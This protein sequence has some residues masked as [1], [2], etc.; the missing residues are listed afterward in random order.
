MPH[1]TFL[2]HGG[3]MGAAMR[4]KDWSGVPLGPPQDWPDPLKALV[5][6]VLASRQPMFL[7]WGDLHRVLLYNDAYAVLLGDKH[8]H[9]LGRAFTE[10][11][12][13]AC[14]PLTELV[15]TVF[16]GQ[17]LFNEDILLMLDRGNGLQEAHFTYSYTPV[18]DADGAVLG[19]FCACSE[20][21]VAVSERNDADQNLS[22][23]T[24]MFE[25]APGWICMLEGPDHRFKL[26]NRAHRKIL[27][28][29]VVIGMTVAEL[30]P[31][32]VEQ[33]FVDLL[34][35]VYASGEALRA[36][37]MTF[38]VDDASGLQGE[39]RILDFVYQPLTNA[40][41]EVTGIFCEGADVTDRARVEAELRQREQELRIALNAGGFGTWTHNFGSNALTT[42][43]IYRTMFGFDPNLRLTYADLLSRVHPDDLERRQAALD[44]S[45]SQHCDYKVD[46]RIM[47]TSREVRWLSVWGQWSYDPDGAPLVLSGVSADITERKTLEEELRCLNEDLERRVL[48]RT[49]ELQ[50]AE[51]ALRQAQKMEAVGQLTGGIAHDFNNLLMG[52]SG[53]LELVQTRLAQDRLDTLPRYIEAARSAVARAAALTQRLLAFSRR[54]TLDPGAVEL[55]RLVGGMED[56]IGRTVGPDIEMSVTSAPDLWR[57]LVD[58]HQF[59]NALLNLCINA[60]DAMP[61]GGLLTIE[62]ENKTVEVRSAVSWDLPVGDYTCLSVTDTGCGMSPEVISR[63]F[64]PFFT[65]KPLGQG[66]G[67]GLS[68]IYGFVRQ[69]GGEV[70]IYSEVGRGTTVCIY[71]PR[72]HGDTE[73]SPP[74]LV[75]RGLGMEGHGE[76]VL[77]V[78]DEA[79]VRMLISEVLQDAGYLTI[80]VED[81]PAGMNVLQSNKRIDLLITDVGLP[82]GMNGRQVADAA[83][84][85]RPELKV[86]FVTGYAENAVVRNGRLEDGMQII[87]KP[88]SVGAL[89]DKVRIL[90]E[91]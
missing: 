11:W 4:A 71:L 23:L 55:N 43:P 69:S 27:N 79:M 21:T 87:T 31:E 29:R 36:T 51:A 48:A 16:E 88:F 66:T 6:V 68:M 84:V 18:R 39:D 57:T 14:D 1:L 46:Y 72:F 62:T 65:T 63:A 7:V 54:Q 3:E 41:G 32:V 64:D 22:R 2:L 50:K 91:S 10:V 90:I 77:V 67:L 17:A 53:S 9:A 30:F 34:D 74:S 61:D 76:T 45:L 33:G 89:G 83:R 49:E 80:E 8:P 5:A 25:Q 47:T 56:L 82:G 26:S 20:T 13:E 15:M 35:R 75:S 70:R 37:Q 28:D 52:I 19:I 40:R 24:Q 60:R 59:E 85:L 73:V 78:D 42:S 12:C 86:L 81:G 44:M 38:H 58:S